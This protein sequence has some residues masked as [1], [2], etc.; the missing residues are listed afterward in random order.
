MR[1]FYSELCLIGGGIEDNVDRLIAKGAENIELMLDGAGWNEFHLRKEEI[2][3]SLRT[4]KVRYSV[5]V[6]VWGSNLTYEN[7]QYRETVLESYRQS[8][9]F[10]ALVEAGH[11]VLHPGACPDLHFSK[12][13]ARPRSA[14]AMRELAAFDRPHG[15]PLLVENVGTP[16]TSIFD[17]A[18]FAAFLD[19]MPDVLGYL[20]DVGHAHVSGW[21]LERLFPALGPRFRALHL[22]DNDGSRDAHAPLGAGDVDWD[23]VLGAAAATGRDL[24]LVLEY[25]IGTDL[26]LLPEGKARVEAA[27]AR[28]SARPR[29]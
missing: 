17:E 26:G 14:A 19:G 18:Q 2:A 20:V 29:A 9:A 5:H 23:R 11:V 28:A 27:W 21:D 15:I 1:I 4:K 10:A 3:R 7:A 22:H 16:A 24:A 6:P 12:E 8:I 25:N 13:V